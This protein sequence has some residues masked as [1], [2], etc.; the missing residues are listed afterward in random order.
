MNRSRFAFILLLALLLASCHGKRQS[1]EDY[2]NDWFNVPL[3]KGAR[4]SEYHTTFD[5]ENDH[6]FAVEFQDVDQSK[7][8]FA[9]W[10]VVKGFSG[11]Q[12][13]FELLTATIAGTQFEKDLVKEE[14][15]MFGIVYDAYEGK[16]KTGR[17][18]YV[19]L[20]GRK[21]RM[22]VIIPG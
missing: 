13:I 9:K 4:C 8:F 1:A 3:P 18:V 19:Y 5:R 21:L 16:T 2:F 6:I 15:S 17:E 12:Q 11:E 20:S 14:W 22:L 10:G 7:A